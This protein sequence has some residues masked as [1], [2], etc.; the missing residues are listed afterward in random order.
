M[1]VAPH[2][3]T[4]TLR[5]EIWFPDGSRILTAGANMQ[6]AARN[7]SPPAIWAIA[8]AWPHVVVWVAVAA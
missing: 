5:K 1:D 4:R 6:T 3:R 2:E 7:A 8:L